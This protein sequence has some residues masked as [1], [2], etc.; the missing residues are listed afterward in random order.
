[1]EGPS[2][3]D[4]AALK[5]D[6]DSDQEWCEDSPAKVGCYMRYL[7]REDQ[8]YVNGVI[9]ALG[10]P[11]SAPPGFRFEDC[12]PGSCGGLTSEASQCSRA[13]GTANQVRAVLPSDARQA[14]EGSELGSNSFALTGSSRS[15]VRGRRSWVQREQ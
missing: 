9:E 11:L 5:P 12:S 7:N 14:F 1:M 8:E 2:Y 13:R 4:G 6:D 10:E 3:A 15:S